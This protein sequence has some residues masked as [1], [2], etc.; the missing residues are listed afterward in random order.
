MRN[1]NYIKFVEVKKKNTVPG[2]SV[3]CSFSEG[4]SG[5]G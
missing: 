3:S 1:K 4:W 5:G 2:V